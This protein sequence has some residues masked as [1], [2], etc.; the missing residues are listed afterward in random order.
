MQAAV[1]ESLNQS[2]APT[3]I[4]AP[5]PPMG[6]TATPALVP[7]LVPQPPTGSTAAPALVPLLR[8][9]TI[10]LIGVG[11]TTEALALAA[12]GPGW[13]AVQKSN[14]L[15]YLVQGNQPSVYLSQ[16]LGIVR[17]ASEATT[18]W[19]TWGTALSGLDINQLEGQQTVAIKDGMLASA[20]DAYYAYGKAYGLLKETTLSPPVQC[21]Q[22]HAL[23]ERAMSLGMTGQRQTVIALEGISQGAEFDIAGLVEAERILA[24]SDQASL[25]AV[26]ALASECL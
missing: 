12:A 9:D 22:G 5:H 24:M 18:R 4:F 15:W 23:L 10:D 3:S 8:R 14:H 17:V 19:L 16:A 2:P 20:W 21:Q 26:R 6:A 11:F 25:S 13:F 7:P 1:R